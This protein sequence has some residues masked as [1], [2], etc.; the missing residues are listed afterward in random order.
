MSRSTSSTRT[1]ANN[2]ER[3]REREK[4]GE[5]KE[6]ERDEERQKE[7]ESALPGVYIL[8]NR[9]IYFIFFQI[10]IPVRLEPAQTI[11]Q[12]REIER[13]RMSAVELWSGNA[14]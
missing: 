12:E 1:T 13:E 6:R 9:Y 7:R 11:K 3:E 14:F 2:K 4:K 8:K 5:E 10:Y